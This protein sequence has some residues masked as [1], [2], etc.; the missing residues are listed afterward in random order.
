LTELEIPKRILVDANFLVAYLADKSSSDDCLRMEHF[1]ELVASRKS[2]IVI[3]MPALAEFLVGADEAGI[4]AVNALDRNKHFMLAPFDRAAAFE[5]AQ[6][7][8]AALGSGD[9]KDGRTEPWQH[10]KVDRQIVAIGKACGARMVISMDGA[11]RSTAKR[12]GWLALS[13]QD[14]PLP[15]SAKQG[16]LAFVRPTPKKR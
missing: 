3:P 9:K 8:R 14:L 10:I 11:V 2:Q 5:C 12:V 16:N 4:E 6:L 13:I 15:E 7:D 1:L